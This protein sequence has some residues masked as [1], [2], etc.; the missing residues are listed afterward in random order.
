M[1]PRGGSSRFHRG[2]RAC[3]VVQYMVRGDG[4]PVF[5]STAGGGSAR[6]APATYFDGYGECGAASTGC[7]GP[8]RGDGFAT[9]AGAGVSRLAATCTAKWR[10]GA[11]TQ[12]FCKLW[13]GECRGG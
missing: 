3:R 2:E 6:D 10:C 9:G 7:A 8:P 11:G 1:H 12:G 13:N 5:G 4:A